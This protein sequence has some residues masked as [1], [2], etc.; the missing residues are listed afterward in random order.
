[1]RIERLIER[2]GL[3]AK[4]ALVT[5]IARG[6]A[7]EV[8]PLLAD[9]GAKVVIASASQRI[10][11]TMTGRSTTVSKTIAARVA[12]SDRKVL[13]AAVG[14]IATKGLEGATL[15]AIARQV[16]CSHSLLVHRYG[17][18]NG[19]LLR[20][21]QHVALHWQERLTEQVGEL[22]GLAAV[23]GLLEALI[24]FIQREPEELIA[25][26]RLWFH[27]SPAASEYRKHLA[28]V[29]SQQRELLTGWLTSAKRHGERTLP[30]TP[31]TFALRLSAMLSGFIY[32][33]L[34]DP[35][36][37]VIAILRSVKA[38]LRSNSST[39]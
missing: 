7:Q 31:E 36:L 23:E 32:H 25:M 4:T 12:D 19:L 26:S 34:T 8:A 33:W 29:H 13:E 28:K 35:S 30:Y 2:F 38:D 20:V 37:D 1:M 10:T 5:D 16:G 18:K 15:Q 27:A 3:T 11:A 22:D 17:G 24:Q 14:L 6:P 21:M 9:A 39:P